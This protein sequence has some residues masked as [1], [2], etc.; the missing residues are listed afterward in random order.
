MSKPPDY[1]G[2]PD[3]GFNKREPF[4]RNLID[5]LAGYCD[6]CCI[7]ADVFNRIVEAVECLFNIRAPFFVVKTVF[8]VFNLVGIT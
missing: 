5:S 3:I 8:D 4:R 7:S 2:Q 1:P 6:C